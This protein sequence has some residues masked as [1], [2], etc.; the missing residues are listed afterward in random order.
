MCELTGRMATLKE[1]HRGYTRIQILVPNEYKWFVEVCGS[2]EIIEVF[3][4]EFMLD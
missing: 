4:D 3:E 1:P 2:G